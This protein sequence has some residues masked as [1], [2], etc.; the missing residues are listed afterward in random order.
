MGRMTS[1]VKIELTPVCDLS[2]DN[3]N[4]K[5]DIHKLSNSLSY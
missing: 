3:T 1:S 4:Y 2:S 5:N